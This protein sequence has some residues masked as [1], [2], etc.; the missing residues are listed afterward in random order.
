MNTYRKT[1]IIVGTLY[2][3]GTVTGILSAIISGSMLGTTDFL[4]EIANH[5][6]QFVSGALLIL[7]MGL[8]LAMIPVVMYPILK[9]Y[10]QTLALGYVVFR[11]ALETV[12]YFV[13]IIS[14]LFLLVAS[15]AF[16]GAG[17]NQAVIYQSLSTL[18]LH[19]GDP[20]NSVL[21]I[22]FS[23]GALMFYILLY[24]SKLIPRWLSVW[25]LV[26]VVFYMAAGILTL[27]GLEVGFLVALLAL[28]EMVM[29]VWLI[30]KGF[31][32]PQSTP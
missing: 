13:T 27:F 3:I 25:G 19:A 20:I 31:T 21:E 7:T 30:A 8:A 1:A 10:N 14:W 11:S 12:F 17:A 32:P 15:Q 23:L 18:V 24:R 29:A 28:Q 9:Q 16:L 22:V 26:G 4:K 2:I 6:V 5:Q